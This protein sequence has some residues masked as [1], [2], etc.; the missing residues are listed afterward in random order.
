VALEAAPVVAP[1]VGDSSACR[2]AAETAPAVPDDREGTANPSSRRADRLR[3]D[4]ASEQRTHLLQF[5]R[6]FAEF[7]NILG[8]A[9]FSEDCTV[10]EDRI[11]ESWGEVALRVCNRFESPGLVAATELIFGDLDNHIGRDSRD[12]RAIRIR[13]RGFLTRLAANGASV[14][15]C[16]FAEE[17]LPCRRGTQQRKDRSLTVAAQ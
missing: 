1:V 3:A 5:E 4:R 12:L 2:M 17:S 7:H 15:F 9:F 16:A 6:L 11:D 14:R 8:D 10:D 13:C